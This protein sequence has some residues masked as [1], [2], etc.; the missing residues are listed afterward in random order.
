MIL[1]FRDTWEGNFDYFAV[2]TFNLDAGRGE[3]LGGFH[4]ANYAANALT[5]TRNNLNV[6]F[7]VERLQCC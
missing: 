4:A 6:V 7:S 3:G 1:D 5:V 2:G